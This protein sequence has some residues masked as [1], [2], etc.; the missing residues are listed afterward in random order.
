MPLLNIPAN[1]LKATLSGQL[2]PVE[3]GLRH[4]RGAAQDRVP[5]DSEGTPIIPATEAYAVTDVFGTWRPA[6]ASL[7]LRLDFG[8]DNIA[9]RR[10]RRHLSQFEEAGR[11]L[12][13][14][15]SLLF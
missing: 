12:R 7:D 5:L 11:N 9:D 2:G 15:A 1:T 8:V 14:G 6:I 13:V 4:T 10:W 3:M